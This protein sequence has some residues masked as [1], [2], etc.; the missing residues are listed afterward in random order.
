MIEIGFKY[1]VLYD[2]LENQAFEYG[3]ILENANVYES[4]RAGI[5][6]LKFHGILTDNQTNMMF[7]KLHKQV[8]K[9]L[10]PLEWEEI[11]G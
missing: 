3:Y 4:L 7:K 5:N 1:G 6:M 11:E 10:K 8:V 2:S 9:S